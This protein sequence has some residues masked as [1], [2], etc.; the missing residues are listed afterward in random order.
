MLGLR[1]C[2]R[3]LFRFAEV[4]ISQSVKNEKGIYKFVFA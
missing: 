2:V 1:L 3:V 4:P